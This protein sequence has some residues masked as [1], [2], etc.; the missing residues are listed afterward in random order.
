MEERGEIVG[1]LTRRFPALQGPGKDDICY[2]TQNRQNAVQALAQTADA[3]LVVGSANSSNSNRLV[4]VARARGC[5]A[6]LVD[7]FHDVK[8]AWLAGVRRI[9]I[10]AGASPPEGGGEAPLGP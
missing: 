3:V 10:T 2:A 5:P 8:P 7:S 4:E 9:G 6:Y 1:V